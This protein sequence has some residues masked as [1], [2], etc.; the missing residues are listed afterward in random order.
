[1]PVGPGEFG[2]TFGALNALFTGLAFAGVII[3]I[4]LQREDIRQ[5]GE[6]LKSQGQALEMELFWRSTEFA[7]NHHTELV[8]SYKD[9]A[10]SLL[11]D[12][13]IRIEKTD[14]ADT[15]P[16]VFFDQAFVPAAVESGILDELD[17]LWK[18]TSHM[19]RKAT[20]AKGE[21]ARDVIDQIRIRTPDHVLVLYAYRSLFFR[22]DPETFQR[23]HK[24]EH[25]VDPSLITKLGAHL[26]IVHM[27]QIA[28]FHG[29]Q[30]SKLAHDSH[31]EWMVPLWKMHGPGQ[32]VTFP[33]LEYSFNIASVEELIT[34]FAEH[35][36]RMEE[37]SEG[38]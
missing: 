36:S 7:L 22:A 16:S 26:D 27:T 19:I 18:S 25:F 6:N 3:A 12:I 24:L 9:R 33:K 21:A 8:N 14:G 30:K 13:R 10:A 37:S 34:K 4:L 38:T 35:K 29:V 15:D 28:L 11:S 1:M 32:V 5:Q 31:Y 17:P 20:R 23:I 2:D